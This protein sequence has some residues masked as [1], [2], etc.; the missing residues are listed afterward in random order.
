M[1]QLGQGK[2][3]NYPAERMNNEMIEFLELCF[4]VDPKLRAD[5]GRLL[6]HPFVE[7]SCNSNG[8]ELICAFFPPSHRYWISTK[9]N[10]VNI[11][12]SKSLILFSKC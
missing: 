9:I 7:V 1:Y 10:T 4:E 12:L 8:G 6:N 11:T 5:V 3:P 2:H